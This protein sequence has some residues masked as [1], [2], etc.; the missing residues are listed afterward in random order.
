MIPKTSL[1]DATGENRTLSASGF[2]IGE[3]TAFLRAWLHNPRSVAAIAPSS[4]TAAAL[5]TRGIDART[6][7]V[8]E[9]GPGTGVFTRALIGRGVAEYDL[10]LVEYAAQF[11]PELRRC[12]P[13][14]R[15]LCM[16]AAHLRRLAKRETPRAGVVVSALGLS[17]MPS[18]KVLAILAG[19]FACLR[20]DGAFHQISYGLRC[21]V[22]AQVLRRLGL[23]AT[24]IGGTLRNLPPASVFRI[25]RHRPSP[26]AWN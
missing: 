10:C 9:L 1:L 3:T 18:G 12:F 4:A 22:P 25:V 17:L 6:G 14:A 24:R 8:I 16:D 20:T 7:P 11:V 2:A 15:V 21:P 13:L 19:A 26:L 23:K 5:I